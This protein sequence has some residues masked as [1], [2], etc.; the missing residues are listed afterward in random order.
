MNEDKNIQFLDKIDTLSDEAQLYFGSKVIG[1]RFIDLQVKYKLDEDFIYNLFVDIVL[2]NF[3]FSLLDKGVSQKG[4]AADI[5]GH[6]FLPVAPFI[7]KD[8]KAEIIKRGGLAENY[9]KSIDAFQELISDENFN[10]VEEMAELQESTFNPEEEENASLRIFSE[11]LKD[12]LGETD[13]KILTDLNGALVYLL[14]N[15]PDFS[16]KVNKA[17]LNNQEVLT[18]K[19][20]ILEGKLQPGTIANWLKHFISEN[21]S[22]NFNIVVL[23]KY[24]TTTP[25]VKNLGESDRR[26]LRRLLKLYRSLIFYPESMAGLSPEEW[27]IIPLE[28]ESREAAAPR[29]SIA[30]PKEAKPEIKPVLAAPVP[31]PVKSA[32][33]APKPADDL[34]KMLATYPVGSLERRALEQEIKKRQNKI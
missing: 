16:V 10:F 27:E 29:R 11:Q 8:V 33:A 15:K 9:Q 23:S 3:D 5:L 4:L 17:L 6:L 19:G 1:Q 26:L 28:K 20:V 32:A 7:G 12:I 18:E 30:I 31:A 22:E 13:Q 25:S 34:E 21:G 2:A 14:I 24:L